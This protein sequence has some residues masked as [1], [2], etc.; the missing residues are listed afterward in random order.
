MQTLAEFFGYT[1]LAGGI[2]NIAAYAAFIGIIVGVFSERYRNLLITIGAAMLALYAYF[3]LH[4][5]LFTA[6]QT[7]IVVSGILQWLKVAK[8]PAIVVILA[9]TLAAYIFLASIG[10]ITG[11]WGLIGSF[12][13]LGIAL[14]LT[15]L[16]RRS[17]FLIMAGGGA[18]L[19]V[20]GFMVSAWVFFF[21]N[22]FF[23]IANMLTW[24]K[25]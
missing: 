3:F 21:L 23:A 1:T 25:Q 17:G 4:D 2:W 19:V 14:G 24:R 10:A 13:L 12:G 16:P 7:I 22:I 9:A 20:Y 11:A 8:Y 6:L 18:L 5:A 15:I